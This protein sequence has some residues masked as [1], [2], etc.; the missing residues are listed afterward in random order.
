MARLPALRPPVAID[1]AKDPTESTS[2][3]G[4]EQLH[5]RSRFLY[6]GFM[7]A[8]FRDVDPVELASW[9]SVCRVVLNL[10]ETI[11]RY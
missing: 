8:D 6:H 4:R 11:T 7:A 1:L 9:T 2:G 10:H 5:Q 3:L